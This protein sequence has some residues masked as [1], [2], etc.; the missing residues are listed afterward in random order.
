MVGDDEDE[1]LMGRVARGDQQA[2]RRL[3]D[4]HMA[5]TIRLAERITGNSLD[6]DEIAQ[7]AFMRVW[8]HAGSFD[9]HRARFTTWLYR[10]AV[11]LALDRKRRRPMLPIETAVA[12]P[13]GSVGAD[14]ALIAREKHRLAEA[15][16]AQLPERQR[17]AIALVYLEGLSGKEGAAI[18]NVSEKSFESLLSRG[19][20][21]CRQ[22]TAAALAAQGG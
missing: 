19:R 16:L 5:R 12:V 6:G 22:F 11:N 20:A 14:E 13:D 1:T 10:I 7:E 3:M 8:R 15:A 18:L 17:A 4:R 21:A 9:R 2:L